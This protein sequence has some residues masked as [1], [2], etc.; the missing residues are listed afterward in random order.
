MVVTVERGR[1]S[2]ALLRGPRDA[3]DDVH[4]SAAAARAT[5]R[6]VLAAVA[7]ASPAHHARSGASYRLLHSHVPPTE[8][9]NA[10]V[11]RFV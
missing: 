5:G 2:A 4:R 10:Q 11:V 8:L 9:T 6:P 7:A 1:L 3:E